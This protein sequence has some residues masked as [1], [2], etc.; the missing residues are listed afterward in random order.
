MAKGPWQVKDG[1]AVRALDPRLKAEACRAI[2]QGETTE[3]G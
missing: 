2:G 1:F 3:W